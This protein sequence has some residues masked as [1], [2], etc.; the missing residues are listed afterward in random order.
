MKKPLQYLNLASDLRESHLAMH[1]ETVVITLTQRHPAS[2]EQVVQ[3]TLILSAEER[4]RSRYRC[5]T[6]TGAELL[7]SL[8]RGTV[9]TDGDLLTTD[10]Q[11]WWARVEA[12]AEP[13]LLVQATHPLDLL[14]AAYH[15]G[16]RHVPLQ[17]TPQTIKL[18]TDPVLREMLEHLGLKV[19]EGLEPFSPEAGAYGHHH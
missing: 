7:L 4:Q 18:S 15:L 6:S 14:R 16:N 19:S 12:K 2:A 11:N 1:Q 13:V 5:Q 3:S 17:I 9:L 10:L 8:P